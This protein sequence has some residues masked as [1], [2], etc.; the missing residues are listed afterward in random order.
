MLDQRW[1]SPRLALVLGWRRLRFWTSAKS[2][3]LA[4]GAGA[5]PDLAAGNHNGR[6]IPRPSPDDRKLAFITRGVASRT[7][8]VCARVGSHRSV[9][10]RRR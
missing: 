8:P 2:R 6:A 7:A 5:L 9:G 10:G 4:R 1:A 3:P